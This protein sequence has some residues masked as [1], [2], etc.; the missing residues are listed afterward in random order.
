MPGK[1]CHESYGLATT[2]APF[3]KGLFYGG[4]YG[5]LIAQLIGACTAAI[6]AFIL[7][8]ILFKT[9][10]IMFGIRVSPEEE[11]KG[12]DLNHTPPTRWGIPPRR[13][14]R[15]GGRR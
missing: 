1:E 15:V 7:G 4:G 2:N 6:W 10:D 9:M 11:L 8:F 14:T 5:Q 3:V 12:L 13:C